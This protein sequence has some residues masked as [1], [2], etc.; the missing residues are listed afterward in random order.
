MNIAPL[1]LQKVGW[2]TLAGLAVVHCVAT[3]VSV[4]SSQDVR[5]RCLITGNPVSSAEEGLE[6][7]STAGLGEIGE[8]Y[9]KGEHPSEGDHLVS[10]GGRR[11]ESFVDLAATMWELGDRPITTGGTMEP[12]DDPLEDPLFLNSTLTLLQERDGPRLVKGVFRRENRYF[13]AWLPLEPQP[14]TRVTASIV[15]MVLQLGVVLVAGLAHWQRPFDRPLRLFFI[16]SFVSLVAFV[17]GSHWW[18]ISGSLW[19]LVPFVVAIVLLPAVLLHFFLL[20]PEP[21]RW[22]SARAG[23]V[24]TGVYLLPALA[25]VTAVSMILATTWL[26]P[27]LAQSPLADVYQVTSSI[28][29]RWILSGLQRLITICMVLSAAYFMLS[30]GSLVHAFLRSRP[31]SEHEQV[32]WILAAASIALIPLGYALWLAFSDRVRLV[33]GGAQLPL[34]GASLLFTAAYAIGIVRHRLMLIDQT[35]N[36]GLLYYFVSFALTL[37]FAA[38]VAYVAMTTLRPTASAAS[39]PVL[40]FVVATVGVITLLWLRDR[41]QLGIDLEFF[42]EKYQ[43]DKTLQRV[44]QAVTGMVDRR[45]LADRVLASCQDVL[46]ANRGAIYLRDEPSRLFYRLSTFGAGNFPAEFSASREFVET[47]RSGLSLQRVRSGESPIQQ[48]MRTLGAELVHG[49]DVDGSLAG[50]IVLGGKPTGASYTAEDAAFLTAIGRMAGVTLHFSRVH[51]ELTRMNTDFV[52]LNDELSDRV[53]AAEELSQKL[54]KTESL[55]T[56]QETAVDRLQRESRD[57][58]EV[59]GRA[60]KQLESL[61]T[62][63]RLQRADELPEPPAAEFSA[64]TILG[65]SRPIRSVLETV[66]KVAASDASVLVR[67][68]SGTGKELL[69]RAIHDN[70]PRRAAPLVTIHCAALAPG[71]LESELFGHVKGAFTDARQDKT[72]RFQLADGGTLFLDE[73][74]D[75][76]L[77]TQVKLLR[78]LQ[79]RIIEPVGSSRPVPVDVRL[80]AATHRNLEEFIALGRFRED[81]YYR[82]NVVS[83]TLPPLRERGDDIVELAVKFLRRATQRTG[84]GVSYFDEA[85]LQMLKSYAWPGNVR[86][87]ENAVERAVVL[88]EQD[89]VTVDDLPPSL[90]ASVEGTTM[91]QRVDSHGMA[92]ERGRAVAG[93]P[94]SSGW[95]PPAAGAIPPTSPGAPDII[96]LGS[97]EER[98]MLENALRQAGGNKARAARLLN[99]PRST[100]F[101]KLRKHGLD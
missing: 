21:R 64:A 5:L 38:A 59:L 16:A 94:P 53:A 93:R 36:R 19:L 75:V 74:G 63:L 6:I 79:E 13:P 73:I 100:Y 44:N 84:K 51:E 49:L 25:A 65:N 81:L 40:M 39:Q 50:M 45:T 17:G 69:A 85:A 29:I 54:Q 27:H 41:M 4:T 35:L 87:L 72:G 76:P 30:V 96:V 26:S 89:R 1:E 52:R 77:E 20:Y 48:S 14:T 86:E 62:Q 98:Q 15:W 99:M 68:E 95:T 34:F 60:Q 101:S 42:R 78:V 46:Q 82:L 18:V 43:L 8:R 88:A 24:L 33:F 91:P 55:L 80:I 83:I 92:V 90:Q 32:R 9:I 56:E 28:W 12:G 97:D 11:I 67:G 3:L 23:Q 37:V 61:Q 10:L 66:R 7:R 2:S 31:K 71:V 47:L 22:L 58:E 57:K 70:S